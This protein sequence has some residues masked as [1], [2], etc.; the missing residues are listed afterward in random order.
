M[1]TEKIIRAYIGGKKSDWAVFILSCGLC[2]AGVGY[3]VFFMYVTVSY[4]AS[5]M[6]GN[7]TA[8]M[9]DALVSV[10]ISAYLLGTGAPKTVGAAVRTRR[11]I[12]RIAS[13]GGCDRAAMEL[14]EADKGK[15]LVITEHYIFGEHNGIASPLSDVT[16][17]KSMYNA[18]A[19]Y[20]SS[21]MAVEGILIRL[22]DGKWYTVSSG[23]TAF[24][25][26]PHF[27]DLLEKAVSKNTSPGDVSE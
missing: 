5:S 25:D 8:L 20:Y 16:D 26:Y 7:A 15:H 22:T 1:E 21:A 3:L 10:F 27:C 13:G 12:E 2:A 17:Y 6:P 14:Y 9:S 4:G 23:K 24:S 11:S 19:G 18:H